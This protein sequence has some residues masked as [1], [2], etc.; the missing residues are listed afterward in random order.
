MKNYLFGRF[1]IEYDPDILPVTL[2][3]ETGEMLD[4]W[5]DLYEAVWT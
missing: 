1:R 2:Y 5:D 3:D 4:W